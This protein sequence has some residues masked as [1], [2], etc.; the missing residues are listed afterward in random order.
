MTLTDRLPPLPTPTSSWRRSPTGRSRSRASRSTPRRRRRCW[1][2]SPGANVILSTPTGS[3][4]SLVAIGAHAAALAAR[5]AQ[6]STRRRSRRWSA[7]SSSRSSTSS[8]RTR[9]GMLTGDAAVNETAPIICCT[10]EILANIA[11]R[12]G[13]ARGRRLGRH[14]RVPLLRRP[15]PRLGLA[16][17]AG[18][19]AAGAVPAHVGHARRR[20]VLPRRPHPPDGPADRAGHLGRTPRPAA[21]PLRAH[22]A[23]RD[24]HR[25]ARDPRGAGLRRALHPG[26]GGGAGAGAD[27]RQRHRLAR[28]S[29]PSPTSSGTSGSPPASARR[30][31]GWCATASACTTPACCPA[32]GGWWRPSPR[33]A[34]S[35][36]SAAPTPSAS[37]STCRSARCCSPR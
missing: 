23:A 16:G 24:D 13:A 8:A 12:A 19:A 6:R 27:E 31:P 25:A 15:G 3:G 33:P 32:T 36:S 22:P 2:S 5:T 26:V 7:R 11:L 21:L 18:R 20:H 9:S 30:C 34:C 17:A 35:R 1:R 14:G 4:K 10:A 29:R 28:R 37:A